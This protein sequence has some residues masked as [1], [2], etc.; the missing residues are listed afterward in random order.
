MSG[1]LDYA[2]PGI[3][4]GCGFAL[5]AVGLVLTYRATG[6]F[7][8]A[9]GAQAFVSAFA[10]D[11]LNQYEHWSQPAAFAVAVLVIAP[12]LGLA[13][14]RFL[15]RYIPTASVTAKVVSSL[16]L[17]IAIPQAVPIFFGTQVRYRI[18]YLWLSP[19]KVYFT[20]FS[21]PVNGA[22]ISTTVLSVV[23]VAA[24]MALFRWTSA[25]LRMRAVVESRRLA[26]LEGVNSARVAAGA[27]ALSSLLAGLSGVLTLPQTNSIDPTSTLQ[28][29]NLLV[30][31]MTAAALASMRSIPG[32]FAGGVGLGVLESLLVKFMPPGSVLATGL[33]P[34]LPFI[35]L[36]IVLLANPNLRG[37][38]HSADPL[39][40][41]DPPPPPP[42]VAVR[43]HRLDVPI[44]WGWRALVVGFAASLLTWI[45]LNWVF[46]LGQGLV[47]SVMF[48]SI[49]L[50][51]GMSGQLSLCQAA[52]AAVGS[53]GAGQL[54]MH[55][56]F[57][58]LLGM[59]VGG[60]MAAAVGAL[61]SL[62]VIR[63]SGLLLTLVTLAFALFGD[64]V[65]FQFSWSGGGAAG[66]HVPRPQIGSLNFANDRYFAVLLMVILGIC[67]LLVLFVQR[68]TY[69]RYL[70]AMRGSPTGAASL[71]INLTRAKIVIFT[72]SAGIAG[73]G[74]AL[75]GSIQQS[76][77][78][79]DFSYVL[80]LVFVVVVI[81]TGSR[82][83][84]GA[85]QA[86]MGYAV[87][88]YLLTQYVP[89]R[90]VGIEPILFALGALTYAQ[91]PEGIV[92][93]QKTKWLTRTSRALAAWDARRARASGLPP[94]GVSGPGGIGAPGARPGVAP[95]GAPPVGLPTEAL[96]G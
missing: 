67:M 15:F 44:T 94:E 36:V 79:A 21:S 90:L 26:E 86:G 13:L 52:F 55:L 70:A 25:G 54:A 31:G 35:I 7:N 71:G 78:P 16:G 85:V 75:Y 81:T 51:T 30:A 47:F 82:T 95:A 74:G 11:L 46:P 3:P 4:Y 62:L 69:G 14:D 8:L 68:G 23:V 37:L 53:F 12:A 20:L 77:A 91:H 65:L 76:V 48:L 32:A 60:A 24:V 66:L 34:S 84:E 59:V 22:A 88:A 83:V 96:G 42:A 58:I 80:S 93:Y 28:F 63:V 29:T 5:L 72:L 18:G 92:E 57:P 10:Y 50:I 89:R 2:I 41:V 19:T 33:K 73:M 43:D 56:G 1:I 39:A 38:E 6:V 17:F 40:N 45:P 61:I 27:W 64:N 87:I 9:F 49:T